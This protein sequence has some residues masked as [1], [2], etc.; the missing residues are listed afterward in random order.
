[1][2]Y[3]PLNLLFLKSTYLRCLYLANSCGMETINIY[4]VTGIRI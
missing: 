4:I 1:M 2:F 3:L